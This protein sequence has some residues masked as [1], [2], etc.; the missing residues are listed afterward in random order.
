MESSTG[1]EIN[2]A[3]TKERRS[4]KRNG[5]NSFLNK[6]HSI[7]NNPGL[8]SIICWSKDGDSFNILDSE[9]L[10]DEIIPQYFKHRNL[11]SFVRQL[12]LHGFKKVRLSTRVADSTIETYR[13]TLFRQNQ[14]D[15][16]NFIKRKVSKP[17]EQDDKSEQINYL[18]EQKRK[19]EERCNKVR[20]ADDS[21]ILAVISGCQKQEGGRA[22][23]N[24]LQIYLDHSTK[25]NK[26]SDPTS[27][28]IFNLT[29]EYIKNLIALK[30]TS[31]SVEES[32]SFTENTSTEVES[33]GK[34]C[35]VQYTQ[36]TA[37]DN[38]YGDEN[39]FS[40]LMSEESPFN[41]DYQD[42]DR[43]L[44]PTDRNWNIPA[45]NVAN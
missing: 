22:L 13:H 14:P 37:S 29:Q 34:R 10:Q 36:D 7:L 31:N 18:L 5:K 25:S 30:Q 27:L 32:V 28:Y 38:V 21:T 43:Y 8:N 26:E 24:A 17:I 44:P 2:S 39:Y 23:I 45:T 41:M 40:E 20:S 35:D 6:L 11:K 15:L 9:R 1:S 19:L 3:Y 12:N 42:E 4:K 33:L 16:L